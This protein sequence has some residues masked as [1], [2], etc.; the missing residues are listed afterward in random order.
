MGRAQVTPFRMTIS[1]LSG[2]F[3]SVCLWMVPSHQEMFPIGLIWSQ[4]EEWPADHVRVS[5]NKT[6]F[7]K[8]KQQRG[9]EGVVPRLGLPALHDVFPTAIRNTRTQASKDASIINNFNLEG[10]SLVKSF[11]KLC[12]LEGSSTWGTE[13]Q[14]TYKGSSN[15]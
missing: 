7:A 15:N 1:P 14:W 11:S 4:G 10:T 9:L 8:F 12:I 6:H 3:S 13:M 5:A 2:Q